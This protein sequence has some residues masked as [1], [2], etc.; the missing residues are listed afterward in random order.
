MIQCEICGKEFKNNLGGNLTIHLLN[1]HN[2]MMGDYYVLTKLN[3]VEPKCQCGLC[4]D[5]PLFHRGKFSEFAIN[6][7]TF[8]W[9]EKRYVELYS[10]P[11]CHNPNCNNVVNFYRGK[12]NKYCSHKCQPNY[13][14]Q[15]KVKR[16]VN[17][18]Y[19][20]DNVFQ[21]QTIKDKI[22]KTNMAKYGVKYHQELPDF[23]D[24]LKIANINR[25]GVEVPQQLPEFVEK[26]KNSLL[27]KYGVEHYS[28]TNVFKEIASKNMCRYNENVNTNHKIRYY[29]NTEIYYQSM[30]EYR[31]LEYCE[32]NNLLQY[33]D[34]AP[35][36]KYLDSSIGKWHLPDFKFKN[37]FI[38][39][40]KSS[41][42]FKR[43]GGFEKLN[44]KKE[45]VEYAGYQYIFILDENYEEFFNK[46]LKYC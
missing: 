5:R 15:D 44:A 11:K 1:E 28:K 26:K 29:N 34:N 19:S 25:Y 37:S 31:F 39:E 14:N 46:C 40:I 12:P 43:Q 4:E 36:F 24:K 42:W 10:Q 41:Y 27:I 13:W 23:N 33:V 17:N 9:Q 18:K 20:V 2:L 7:D 6:H 3:G 8:E 21:I 35:T 32:K 45:S 30:H 38:I 22:V 16:T